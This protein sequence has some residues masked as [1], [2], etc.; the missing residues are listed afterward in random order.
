LGRDR[1]SSSSSSKLL[2]AVLTDSSEVFSLTCLAETCRGKRRRLQESKCDGGE[3]AEE[4][5]HNRME[6]KR[7]GRSMF[8]EE[9]VA[10]VW[11]Q[12]G[13]MEV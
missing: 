9:V 3:K 7:S 11:D 6:E 4:L 2:L 13:V 8:V 5:S 10:S 1:P 12:D